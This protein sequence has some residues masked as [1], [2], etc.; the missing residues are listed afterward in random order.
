[1]NIGGTTEVV[2]FRPARLNI[3]QSRQTVVDYSL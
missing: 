1:M 2:P 3:T